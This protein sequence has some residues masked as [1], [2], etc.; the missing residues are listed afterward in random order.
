MTEAS[1]QKTTETTAGSASPADAKPADKQANAAPDKP[2]EKPVDKAGEKPADSKDQWGDFKAPE[3]FTLE[4][5]KPIVEWAQKAGLDPKAAAAVAIREKQA[6]EKAEAEFKHLSEKGWLEEL[7]KDPVL[8]GAKTRE[9]MVDVMRAVDKLSPATQK[10]IKDEGVLYNP[11]I[12]R[13]L[14]DM[15]T[16]TREDTFV[17]PGSTPGNTP[18]SLGV[19]ALES[20]FTTPKKS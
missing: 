13:I 12:V 18:K 4:G 9:T 6:A 14:Y 16:K 7:N 2:A 8:G 1:P 20:L 19:D 5:L 3:G 15:G 11:V 17:R 10:I